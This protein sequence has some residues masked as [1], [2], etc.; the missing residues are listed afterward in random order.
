MESGLSIS[1][2]QVQQI[3]TIAAVVMANVPYW[4]VRNPF[5]VLKTRAQAQAQSKEQTDAAQAKSGS[6]ELLN[7]GAQRERKGKLTGTGIGGTVRELYDS[8]TANLLYALPAD[9]IKFL[10]CT[11]NRQKQHSTR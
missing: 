11:Q 5:E 10:A 9:L 6:R 4:L 8:F 7:V 1:A 2:A 3:S